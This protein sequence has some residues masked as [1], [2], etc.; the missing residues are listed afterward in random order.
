MSESKHLLAVDLGV[1]SGLAIYADTG[2][3]V[4]YRSTNFGSRARLKKAAYGVLRDIDGLAHVVAEGDKN[5]GEIWRHDALKLGA[6]FELITAEVWREELLFKRHRRS[7]QHAKARADTLARAVIDESGADRP[8]SLK[9]DAAEAIL[10][11][12]WGVINLGWLQETP[13]GSPD[14]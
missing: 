9:H 1:K 7:G 12:L 14:R 11:G 13:V 5:L 4:A 8:T 6:S 2:R 10:I 3:L